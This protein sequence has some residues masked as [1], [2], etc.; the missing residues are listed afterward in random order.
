MGLVMGWPL[1]SGTGLLVACIGVGNFWAAR[2]DINYY[3]SLQEKN[4]PTSCD[5]TKTCSG[6]SSTKE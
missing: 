3:T 4:D 1:V 5:S 6:S 2:R